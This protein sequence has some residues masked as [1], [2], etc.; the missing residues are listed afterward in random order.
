[1]ILFQSYNLLPNYSLFIDSKS[2]TIIVFFFWIILLQE[3]IPT[4]L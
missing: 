1:M 4:K 2:T 3:L